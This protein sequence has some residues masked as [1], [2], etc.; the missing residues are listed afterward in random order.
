MRVYGF[1][2][3]G[4]KTFDKDE[5]RRIV[6]AVEDGVPYADLA[7]RFRCDH[8]TLRVYVKKHQQEREQDAS[9]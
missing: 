5:V 8:S 6:H 4:K 3:G 7:R 2:S 1:S 9:S